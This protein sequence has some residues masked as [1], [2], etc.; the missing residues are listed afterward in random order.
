[1]HNSVLSLCNK[2]QINEKNVENKYESDWFAHTSLPSDDLD[3]MPILAHTVQ[4]KK[5]EKKD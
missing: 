4:R 5:K 1:M 2:L 3:L